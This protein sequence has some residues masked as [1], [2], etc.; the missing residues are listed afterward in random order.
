METFQLDEP[1]G[2]RVVS[3]TLGAHPV[4][5]RNNYRAIH[6]SSLYMRYKDFYTKCKVQ[7]EA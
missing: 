1:D 2:I 4:F 7:E 6:F 3:E 5:P